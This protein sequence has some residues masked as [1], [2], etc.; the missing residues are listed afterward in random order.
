MKL[1]GK[2]T[3]RPG[4][5]LLHGMFGA[6]HNWEGCVA[7][8]A[9][10]WTVYRPELPIF[11]MPLEE[12][13]VPSLVDY[14]SAFLD[15]K[16]LEKVVLGGNSLGGHVAISH[17]MRRPE[18]VAGLMLVGSSGL[19]DRGFER[20]VPRRPKPEWIRAKIHEVFY[21]ES[22]VS[23]ELVAEISRTLA[24]PGRVR[25][26]IRMAKSAKQDN[27]KES[28]PALRCPVLLIWGAQD[29]ITP[30]VVAQ[31]F[32]ACLPQAELAVLERCGHAP[33]IERPEEVGRLMSAFMERH[34]GEAG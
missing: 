27:L 32:K 7:A 13:G 10:R 3:G 21:E 18:R 9:G 5:V 33:N 23:E 15:R 31:S 12:T 26:I 19:F 28:L 6:G 30:P 4:I 29:Q 2:R 1:N 24:E 17:A 16:G 8:L 14:L 34:F 11:D 25:K 22:Q 20:E